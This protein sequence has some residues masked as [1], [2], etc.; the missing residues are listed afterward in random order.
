[1]VKILDMKNSFKFSKS[2]LAITV[3]KNQKK[4]RTTKVSPA[5]VFRQLT[6]N[7][8][9][10]DVL[11][12]KFSCGIAYNVKLIGAGGIIEVRPPSLAEM[13]NRS[14][15]VEHIAFSPACANEML[16]AVFKL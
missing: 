3:K 1:M 7:V 2:Q 5:A 12:R 14:T 8:F 15:S 6:I 13:L 16:G 11:G 9:C 10:Q 4:Y